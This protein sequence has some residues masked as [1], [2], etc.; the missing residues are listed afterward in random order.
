LD[1]RLQCTT[2]GGCAIGYFCDADAGTC[3]QRVIDG[4]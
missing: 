3:V 1:E 4:G 2:D